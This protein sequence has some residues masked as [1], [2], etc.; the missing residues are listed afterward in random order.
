[1]PRVQNKCS[2]GCM[3]ES[4]PCGPI[5]RIQ[6]PG[7]ATIVDNELEFT[8]EHP[9]FGV[10]QRFSG[11]FDTPT[12]VAGVYALTLCGDTLI[13]SPSTGVLEANREPVGGRSPDSE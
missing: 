3:A 8:E 12:Q 1:M 11:A 6:R 9:A 4:L 5:C 10:V 2:V 7:C 13:T